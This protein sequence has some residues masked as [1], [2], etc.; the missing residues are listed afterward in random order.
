MTATGQAEL[1]MAL[2]HAGYVARG[3]RGLPAGDAVETLFEGAR[4]APSELLARRAPSLSLDPVFALM[5]DRADRLS[6][7][8]DH[9][10]QLRPQLLASTAS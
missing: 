4:V 5:G 1:A 9:W 3:V 8:G 6:D 2:A 7:L 10:G